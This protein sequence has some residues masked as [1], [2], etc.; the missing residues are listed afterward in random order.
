MQVTLLCANIT[1]YKPQESSVQKVAD[2]LF[3]VL[4]LHANT[5]SNVLFEEKDSNQNSRKRAP[6]LID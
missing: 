2:C 6:L 5:N 1:H 3:H 4:A